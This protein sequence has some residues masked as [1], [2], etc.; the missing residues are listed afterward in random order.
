LFEGV[1]HVHHYKEARAI[2]DLVPES[3]LR[4]TPAQ[5]AA[6]YPAQWRELTGA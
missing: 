6:R 5:V 1:G 2:V 4:S 3:T